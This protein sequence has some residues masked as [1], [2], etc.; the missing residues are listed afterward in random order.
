[1]IAQ[2]V[3]F[4]ILAITSIAAAIGVVKTTNIVHSALFLV[5]VLAASA[6][7]FLLIASEF[8]A[9]VQVLIY[10]GAVTVLLLFGIMLTRA[11]MGKNSD[12]DN[13]V[14]LPAYV[15]SMGMAGLLIALITNAFTS[16]DKIA[17]GGKYAIQT[18]ENGQMQAMTNPIFYIYVFAF[19]LV[20]VLLLGALIGAVVLA[21]KD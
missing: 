21:R 8:L 6:G 2:N 15:V 10:I 13:E 16:D 14:K 12:L 1:M 5:V 17:I 20:G 9:W 11:P 3:V 19:E 7:L 18:L 4:F